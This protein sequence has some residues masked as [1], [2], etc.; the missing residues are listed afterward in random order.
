MIGIHLGRTYS[1]V[2]VYKNNAP[3]IITDEDGHSAVPSYVAFGDG[4]P[5]LVGFEALAQAANNPKNTIYD[6]R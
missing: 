1:H 4:R 3:H 6:I 5:A 2:A